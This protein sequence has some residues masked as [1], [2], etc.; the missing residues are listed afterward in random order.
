MN[1]TKTINLELSKRLAPYLEGVETEYWYCDTR[2]G[3]K[4]YNCYKSNQYADME[5]IPFREL[6][7]EDSE[8]ELIKLYNKPYPNEWYNDSLLLKTLTLEE[9]IEFLPKRINFLH[10][11]FSTNV[12]IPTETKYYWNYIDIKQNWKIE[13]LIDNWPFWKTPLEAIEAMLTYLLDNN[14]L[15][16]KEQHPV[17]FVSEE[18]LI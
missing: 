7:Q 2:K 15:P 13:A 3:W 9:V 11:H 14:L 4:E 8:C 12:F 16:K 10:L 18:W 5:F 6:K 1:M 17:S